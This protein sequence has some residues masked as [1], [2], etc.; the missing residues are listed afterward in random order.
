M[1][2]ATAATLLG[3]ATKDLVIWDCD[4]VLVDSEALLKQGEVEALALA[5]Y[6]LGVDDCV[7]LFSG[8]SP[9]AAT[10]NFERE[11][12]KLPENF[13]RD[14]VANSL[15]LFRD[16][17][18]P[19]MDRTVHRLAEQR[20]RMCVASGSPLERVCISVTKGGMDTVFTRDVIFT[21]ELVK[22]GKPAPDLFLLAAE[23]MAT[24]PQRCLVVEDSIA[25]VLAAKAAGMDCIGY[26]GGG[27]ATS[28]WYRRQIEEQAVP[29]AYSQEEVFDLITKNF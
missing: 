26:L 19:L 24:P 23:R 12:G 3:A 6:S 21:R 7:R 28:P 17:L 11:Y 10:R 4:G 25:G 9:D 29:L 22:N 20:V 27:H 13:F 15:Q 14:Q 1:K 16:R 8:F 18:V 2:T 5:G